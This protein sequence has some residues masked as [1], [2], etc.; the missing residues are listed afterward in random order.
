MASE[1]LKVT[2][3]LA[4]GTEIQLDEDFLIG[5]TAQGDGTLG[6]DAELSREHAR[7]SRSGSGELQIEDLGSTNG[8]SVNGQRISAPTPIRP[9]DT[10][11]VGTTTI[12][13]DGVVVA[14][15]DTTAV[16]PVGQ[17][18]AVRPVGQPT[19]QRSGVSR[20]MLRLA[21]QPEAFEEITFVEEDDPPGRHPT[22]IAIGTIVAGLLI[23]GMIVAA[24]LN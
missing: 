3:G 4:S 12:R 15:A 20:T 21:K 5:R 8:T 18:T 22:I 16:R 14:G 10:V 1:F 7:V 17:P 11:K 2:E 23:G 9:G 6:G 19:V 13:V 24:I